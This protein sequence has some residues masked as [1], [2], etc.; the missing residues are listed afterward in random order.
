MGGDRLVLLSNREPYVHERTKRGIK[1][2]MPIGGLVSALDPV[3]RS[4]KGIWVAWGSGSADRDVVDPNNRIKVPQEDPSYLLKRV[5]LT[6]KEVSNYY[7]GFCNRVLWPISHLFLEKAVFKGEYWQAYRKV[8]KK[9]TKAAVE[10]IRTEDNVWVHDF[11]LALVPQL[12]REERDDIKIAHFWHIPFPPCEIFSSIPWR[13]EILE[14]LM[15]CDLIGFH[16]QFYVNN[17]LNTVR[18]EFSLEISREEGI[19][20]KDG[21]VVKVKPFPI[22]IDYERY[23][24]IA[25]SYRV[26]EK[27]YKLRKK[28]RAGYIFFG[29]DRLDYTKGILN[30]LLAFEKFLEEN[31]RYKGSAVLIQVACPS[32]TKVE[33]YRMMKKEIDENIGRINGKFQTPQWTPIIY[34]YRCIPTEELITFYKA[35]DVALITPLR[36]GMNL[37][38]KEYVAVKDDGVLILSEFAGASQQLREAFLVNPFD[39]EKTAQAMEKALRLDREEKEKRIQ[40]LREKIRSYDIHWWLEKFLGEWGVELS[41]LIPA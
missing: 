35:A 26:T 15:G 32:R 3:M 17:F 6:K 40:K 36:D 30:R 33:E 23:R 31:P 16:T 4:C 1:F 21:R 24:E 37:V 12:L 20:Y 22:G 41:P 10:E 13:R 18:R 14:G 25:T 7:Y 8:N 2:K 34:I 11:H 19:I 9:F 38:A 27:A 29:V 5:W 28:L 39:T